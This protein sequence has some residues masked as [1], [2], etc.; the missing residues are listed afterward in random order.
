[1]F[2]VFLFLLW[3]KGREFKGGILIVFNKRIKKMRKEWCLG[4]VWHTFIKDRDMFLIT[5][6]ICNDKP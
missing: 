1:M 3:S 6:G 5:K 2:H 4:R